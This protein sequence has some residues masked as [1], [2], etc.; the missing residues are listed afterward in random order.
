MANKIQLF[1][2][3]SVEQIVS[4]YKCI[5]DFIKRVLRSR[6]VGTFWDLFWLLFFT[7]L[8]LLVNV[9]YSL[10]PAIDKASA[11]ESMLVPSEILAYC[12]SITAPLFLFFGKTHGKGFNAPWIVPIFYAALLV[13]LLA[14]VLTLNAKNGFI[15]SVDLKNKHHDSYLSASLI[16]L[17]LA[18]FFRF[19]TEYQKSRYIDYSAERSQ[20]Q[21]R[22]NNSY[23]QRIDEDVK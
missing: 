8:P 18:I 13:Y 2:T 7:F 1:I 4:L 23:S 20:Q 3:Q 6:V 17:M 16:M 15:S 12:L 19:Y 21:Q 10:I 22:F 5:L 11:F 9:L 14:I